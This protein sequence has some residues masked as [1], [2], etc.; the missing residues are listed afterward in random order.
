[1]NVHIKIEDLHLD[2]DPPQLYL[3]HCKKESNRYVPVLPAL[4]QELRT[5]LN[6][7]RHGYLFESN[8]ND[9]YS[10]RTVQSVVKSEGARG[11]HRK[12]RL[13]SSLLGGETSRALRP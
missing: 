11:W 4:A 3:S 5:H 6:R 13:S 8:R 7:R 9:H 10:V 1:M 12:A 2:A